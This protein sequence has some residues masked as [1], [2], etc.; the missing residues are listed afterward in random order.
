MK[1]VR[2]AGL[3]HT[4]WLSSSTRANPAETFQ[5]CLCRQCASF[6]P[7]TVANRACAQLLQLTWRIN[8]SFWKMWSW[9]KHLLDLWAERHLMINPCGNETGGFLF[10]AAICAHR[11]VEPFGRKHCRYFRVSI[12]S[13]GKGCLFNLCFVFWTTPYM[14]NRRIF[15]TSFL[16]NCFRSFFQ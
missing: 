4:Y 1:G 6:F 13:L 5:K 16:L 15:Q 14:A 8:V 3:F 9:Q 10:M 7:V 12:E 2:H 11:W